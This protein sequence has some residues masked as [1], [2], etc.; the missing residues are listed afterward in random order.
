MAEILSR[1]Q[2]KRGMHGFLAERIR[3][4]TVVTT[5]LHCSTPILFAKEHVRNYGIVPELYHIVIWISP[6]YNL[7]YENLLYTKR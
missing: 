2:I 7:S 4:L 3:F 5:N 1:E 6:G